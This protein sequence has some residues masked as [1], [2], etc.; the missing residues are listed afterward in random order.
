[1]RPVSRGLPTGC[2]L[3]L[4]WIA[5]PACNTTIKSREKDALFVTAEAGYEFLPGRDARE[6]GDVLSRVRAASRSGPTATEPKEP[7]AE[8]HP[9]EGSLAIDAAY[10]WVS[11]DDDQRLRSGQSVEWDDVFFI[12][13]TDIDLDYTLMNSRLA[14][15][16]GMRLFDLASLEGIVGLGVFYLDMQIREPGRE[17]TADR[18]FV[19]GTLGGRVTLHP[20]PMIDLRAQYTSTFAPDGTLQDAEFLGVLHLTR[21]LS[22]NGGWRWWHLE[23][24]RLFEIDSDVDI[25]ISGPTVGA[26]LA[27]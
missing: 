12:G 17:S 20:D 13:P 9:V 7:P 5:L 8:K 11:A 25:R 3:L 6:P 21:N 14:V 24:N 1:M 19:G 23:T 26:A 18:T 15:R 16:G 10:G 27:F 4:L 2:L 22:V